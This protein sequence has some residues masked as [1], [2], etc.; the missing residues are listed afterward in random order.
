MLTYMNILTREASR[1]SSQLGTEKKIG[2]HDGGTCTVGWGSYV[3]GG[4][5]WLFGQLK[6]GAGRKPRPGKMGPELIGRR[7]IPQ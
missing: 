2:G 3:L 7:S 1:G 5:K 4:A 6:C